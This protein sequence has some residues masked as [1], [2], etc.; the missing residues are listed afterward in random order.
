MDALVNLLKVDPNAANAF[1]AIASA[2]AAFLALLV[3]TVSVFVSMHALAIQ[4]KHNILSVRPL[5]EVMVADYE[6]SIRIRLRNNGSGPLIILGLTVSDGSSTKESL[7]KWMPSLPTQRA[8]TTFSHVLKNQTLL[9]G[10]EIVLLELTEYDGENSFE[11]CRVIVREALSKLIVNVEY[12]DIYN[13]VLP[14]HKKPL[15]W[16]GR[17]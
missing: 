13:T 7:V 17:N 8:W 12:S 10:D 3:S 9:P 1:G 15:S 4:R 16:Y 11:K 2:A 5:A 6:N 14:P